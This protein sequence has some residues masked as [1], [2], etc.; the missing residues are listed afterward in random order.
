MFD[1]RC[2]TFIKNFSHSVVFLSYQPATFRKS[3]T[4][5]LLLTATATA[6]TTAT[7]TATATINDQVLPLTDLI[8]P[9]TD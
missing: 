5:Y 7:A 3:I 8:Q 2:L 9:L 6:T 1:V 4:D